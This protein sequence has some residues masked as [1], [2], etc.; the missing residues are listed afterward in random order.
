M[1]NIALI[2]DNFGLADDHDMPLLL[3]ACQTLGLAATI[4]NWDD[5]SVDWARFNALLLRS[6]WSYIDRLPNFLAWCESVSALTNLLN[7]I[8]AVH[9]SLNKRYLADLSGLGIPVVPSYFV[10]PGTEPQSA[11]R[12]FF[13]THS[14]PR[15]IVIKPTVGAYSKDVQRFQSV[16][17]TAAVK[18]IYHLFAKGHHVIIQPYISS[19]DSVGET[20]LVYFDGAYSHAIRKNALLMSDGTVNV[21]DQAFR[22]ARDASEDEKEVASAALVAATKHLCLEQPLLYARIDLTRDNNDKPMVLEME[23][24]EPSLNLPFSEGSAM[25]FAQAL[26]QR[27]GD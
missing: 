12:S 11:L 25:R 27:L 17:E 22:K 4:C 15:E 7:P 21:P 6:P 8:S 10:E 24:C 14:Q 9:W 1:K 19:I 13:D 5:V 18:H 3:D 2:T 26:A 20:N 23:L 16:H